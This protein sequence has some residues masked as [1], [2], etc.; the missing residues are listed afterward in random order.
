MHL[1]RN[2]KIAQITTNPCKLFHDS[3]S[4]DYLKVRTQGNTFPFGSVL[5]INLIMVMILA[6]LFTFANKQA[7]QLHVIILGCTLG[8]LSSLWLVAGPTH[9][10]CAVMFVITLSI[11]EAMWSPR[12]FEYTCTIAPKGREGSYMALSTPPNLVAKLVGGALSGWLLEEYCRSIVPSKQ[13]RQQSEMPC[14]GTV[15]WLFVFCIT[16]ST[17]ILLFLFRGVL[18][19]STTNVPTDRGE[20][21]GDE[22]ERLLGNNRD[23]ARTAAKAE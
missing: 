4:L 14:D 23:L 8:A 6:P 21:G 18:T 3:F 9:V 11:G 20:G 17:P 10:W 5:A 22:T 16:A 1:T 2:T 19:V 7:N 13:Q 12:V 15:V